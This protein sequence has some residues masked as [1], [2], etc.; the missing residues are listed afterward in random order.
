M[1]RIGLFIH[2]AAESILAAVRSIRDDHNVLPRTQLGYG[3]AV[4]LKELQVPPLYCRSS[5][6]TM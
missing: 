5:K 1:L 2:L 3:F 6:R 4:E